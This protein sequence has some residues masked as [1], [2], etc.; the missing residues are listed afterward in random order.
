MNWYIEP[1]LQS[2]L[3]DLL[4]HTLYMPI[5]VITLYSSLTKTER[6]DRPS[7]LSGLY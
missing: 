6:N 7:A 5:N 2:L 4:N 1:I 3:R